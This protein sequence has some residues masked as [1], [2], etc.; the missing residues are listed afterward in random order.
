PE[1]RQQDQHP[2][3]SAHASIEAELSR[4]WTLQNP[5]LIAGLEA[6]ALRQFDQPIA[7]ALAEIIADLVSDARRP[8][9]VHDQA[10]NAEAPAGGISLGLHSEETITRKERRSDL[11]LASV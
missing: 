3:V 1:Q 8:D 5:H 11:D 7:L 4:K 2:L 10:D 6:G 9:A